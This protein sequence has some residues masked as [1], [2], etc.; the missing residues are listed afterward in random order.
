M[1]FA[2][3]V[4]MHNNNNHGAPSLSNRYFNSIQTNLW[5]KSP[6]PFWMDVL[7]YFLSSSESLAVSFALPFDI[8]SEFF[9]CT[10]HLFMGQYG[11]SGVRQSFGTECSEK[12]LY[13]FFQE[14]SVSC[15]LIFRQHWAAIGCTKNDQP[16]AVTVH[17][18]Y[19]D[20]LQR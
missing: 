13:F 12:K 5:L 3:P 9:F 14:Y 18:Y 8:L 16:I 17:S 7:V 2:H 4:G 19:F 15:D 11:I 10:L 20:N 1:P 6:C